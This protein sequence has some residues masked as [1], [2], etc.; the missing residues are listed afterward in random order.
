MSTVTRVAI[1]TWRSVAG[2]SSTLETYFRHRRRKQ[3]R[4]EK[5][6]TFVQ[7]SG[8]GFVV[9]ESRTNR[10][11]RKGILLRARRMAREVTDRPTVTESDLDAAAAWCGRI[12]Q[13]PI[14][15]ELHPLL[16]REH[17]RIFHALVRV[18]V[19]E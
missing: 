11:P 18:A 1:E 10:E 4:R 6:P 15:D 7:T 17:A 5:G 3:V 8:K 19:V 9:L 16:D 2:K 14:A 13:R 12:H